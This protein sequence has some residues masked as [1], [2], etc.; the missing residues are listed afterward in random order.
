MI[1][2]QTFNELQHGTADDTIL[3]EPKQN[4]ENPEKVSDML[5]NKQEQS[6]FG[7]HDK[8]TPKEALTE[9]QDESAYSMD[10]AYENGDKSGEAKEKEKLEVP[11]MILVGSKAKASKDSENTTCTEGEETTA[12]FEKIS[13]K[14]EMKEEA[15]DIGGT[16]ENKA[17]NQEV[18]RYIYIQNILSFMVIDLINLYCK[19]SKEQAQDLSS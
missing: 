4:V 9:D 18:T 8:P 14:E 3:C 16:K 12:R 1:H 13:Q 6:L 10:V 15:K 7:E 11:D 5:P 2:I 19:I 17:S